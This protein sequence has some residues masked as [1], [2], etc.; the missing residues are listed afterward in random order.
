MLN[1]LAALAEVTA[2]NSLGVSRPVFTPSS[3]STAKRSSTPPQPLGILLK[4][5]LPAAFCS[6]QKVQWSVAVVC[7]LPAC[8]PRHRNVLLPLG[9]NGGLITWPAAYSND[10]LR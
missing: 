3:Q 8:S 4:S 1:S 6:A 5:A 7:R 2:T 10:G 9:R